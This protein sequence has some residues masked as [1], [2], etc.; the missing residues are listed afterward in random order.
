MEL[1]NT[2]AYDSLFEAKLRSAIGRLYYGVFNLLIDRFLNCGNGKLDFH[3]KQSLRNNDDTHYALKNCISKTN[4]SM[5]THIDKLR[6][7]RNFCDYDLEKDVM[8]KI[9]IEKYNG[10]SSL[11]YDDIEYAYADA[12]ASTIILINI[13]TNHQLCYDNR[14]YNTRIEISDT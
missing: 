4:S 1:R 6:A 11:E 2:T 7:L 8:T 5:R 9:T 12:M 14:G 13:Y 10:A 3:L